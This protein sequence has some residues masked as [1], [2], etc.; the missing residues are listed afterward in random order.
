MHP[1]IPF[2][3][4]D[5][6]GLAGRRM[7]ITAGERDPICPPAMTRALHGYFERQHAA[8]SWSFTQAD[9]SCR[10]P[11][12]R[13]PADSWRRSLL[14]PPRRRLI[15]ISSWP[16]ALGRDQHARSADFAFKDGREYLTQALSQGP[17]LER[18]AQLRLPAQSLPR[19]APG[20]EGGCPGTSG[21]RGVAKAARR[22]T[23]ILERPTAAGRFDF[24]TRLVAFP[25]I[26]IVL[27]PQAPCPLTGVSR[28]GTVDPG[29][30][31]QSGEPAS[32]PALLIGVRRQS[33]ILGRSGPSWKCRGA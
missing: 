27:G 11:S 25:M 31:G 7:L 24:H 8:P 21:N 9:T 14:R 10:R 29:E 28:K 18:Q 17:D 6:P 1:L 16:R 5:Q 33:R 26:R 3:P 20:P 30:V 23:A 19:H 4:A 22:A 13:P 32:T 12:S 15:L 2:A